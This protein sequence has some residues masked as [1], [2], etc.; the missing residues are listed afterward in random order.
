[1]AF[2]QTH[3]P[4][5]RRFAIILLLLI[6]MGT[7]PSAVPQAQE[8]SGP[9]MPIKEFDQCTRY[10]SAYPTGAMLFILF[11]CYGAPGEG[12]LLLWRSD[13]TTAGT[14]QITTLPVSLNG[15]FPPSQTDTSLFFWTNTIEGNQ[16]WKTDGMLEG[17][18]PLKSTGIT[19]Q[20][21]SSATARGLFY[22]VLR[23]QYPSQSPVELWRSDGTLEGTVLLKEFSRESNYFLEELNDTLL[24]LTSTELWQSSGTPETTYPFAELQLG[25]WKFLPEAFDGKLL[26][27][28]STLTRNQSWLTDGTAAGTIP[29]DFILPIDNHFIYNKRMQPVGAQFFFERDSQSLWRSNGI[30]ACTFP[31]IQVPLSSYINNLSAGQHSLVFAVHNPQ[32]T[33]L[34]RSDGSA[35]GTTPIIDFPLPQYDLQSLSITHIENDSHLVLIKQ[36]ASFSPTL[37]LWRSDGTTAGT[38]LVQ[39]GIPGGSE[40]AAITDDAIYFWGEGSPPGVVLWKLP[41]TAL[42]P[43][44]D[45]TP[46]PSPEPGAHTMMLPLVVDQC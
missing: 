17:T 4:H 10:R 14:V 3:H 25:N 26:I 13:G 1:M 38:T 32:S 28:E 2:N 23:E 24:L 35:Y 30:T 45:A 33:Q 8:A 6:I 41:R 36:T 15:I 12:Q 39:A 20:I 31:V 46:T 43:S 42:A 16:L 44:P 27:V 40:V 34:W 29:L 9:A 37:S 22:F 11:Q 5:W 19:I 18:I 7:L 21:L